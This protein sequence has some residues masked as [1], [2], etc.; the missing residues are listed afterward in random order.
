MYDEADEVCIASFH[1]GHQSLPDDKDSATE[2]SSDDDVEVVDRNH[3]AARK[4]VKETEDLEKDNGSC[5]VES[6]DEEAQPPK[7]KKLQK[8][9]VR[10]TISDA[11]KELSS[12]GDGG[13]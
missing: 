3:S 13:C 2:R 9:R 10:D 12:S 11:R 4:V 8:Q 5:V 1:S 6:S 7:A